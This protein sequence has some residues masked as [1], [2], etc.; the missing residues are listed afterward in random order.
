MDTYNIAR[1]RSYAPIDVPQIFTGER[2]LRTAVRPG[3]TV[4]RAWRPARTRSSGGWQVN[5]IVSLRGGFPTDIRTNVLP[6][7]FNT[8]NVADR[9]AG[10]TM[11]VN[12]WS[13]DSYFNPAAFTVPG[14][15]RSDHGRIDS[16]VRQL[17]AARGPRVQ[18]RRTRTSRSSRT[19]FRES[20]DA[21]VPRRVLQLHE[22][23]D[24]L[25]SGG[26]QPHADLHR[27]LPAA[28]A[29][30]PTRPSAN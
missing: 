28:R 4:A 6:P 19:T 7:I 23:P 17:G 3:K 14:T 21:T 1:E 20:G 10:Q 8:F 25:P 24:V 26:E 13:V 11:V 16:A 2:R 12:N 15:V 27:A 22:H 9:V 5:T 30:H 18:D 29:T